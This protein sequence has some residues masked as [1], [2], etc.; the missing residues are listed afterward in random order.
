[1]NSEEGPGSVGNSPA[2]L[3]MSI[4]AG[5]EE[6]VEVMTPIFHP[7]VKTHNFRWRKI[8]TESDRDLS[9]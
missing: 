4:Q 6:M 9:L 5:M 7:H 1:M 8:I 3:M 2:W